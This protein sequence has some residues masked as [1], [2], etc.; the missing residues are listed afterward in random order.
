MLRDK[1]PIDSVEIGTTQIE[2]ALW[3]AQFAAILLQFRR[4]VRAEA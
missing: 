2:A 1:T 3:A 4:A